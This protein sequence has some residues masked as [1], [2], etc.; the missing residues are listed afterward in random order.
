[1]RMW[2][3]NP[4]LLC[5]KHLLGEHS[6]IHKHRHCFEKH[7]NITGRIFPVVQIEPAAMQARHDILAAELLCRGFSHKSPYTQPDISYLPPEQQNAIVDKDASAMDLQSRCVE[8]R[9]RI[10]GGN[11]A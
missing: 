2:M 8:C 7:H 10:N 4:K 1:M 5:N 6:E 3:L 11:H 9:I